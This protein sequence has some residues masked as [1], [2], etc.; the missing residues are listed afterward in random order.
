MAWITEPVWRRTGSVK[1]RLLLDESIGHRIA[2]ALTRRGYRYRTAADLVG[3]EDEDVLAT[4][5][6]EDRVVFTLD[7]D[8]LDEKRFQQAHSPG[9]IF[10]KPDVKGEDRLEAVLDI[11]QSFVLSHVTRWSG[12][13][14]RV[15]APD[16]VIVRTFIRE[17]G[18]TGQSI[19]RV[20]AGK[21]WRWAAPAYGQTASDFNT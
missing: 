7:A 14:V 16:S 3:H 2:M 9:V 4:A 20:R 19:Y 10:I 8:F 6:R 18:R 11:L 17:L 13:T 21:V 12:T 5:R 15:S 1:P